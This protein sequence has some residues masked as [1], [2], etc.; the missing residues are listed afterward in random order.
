VSNLIGVRG[1]TEIYDLTVTD[2]VGSPIDLTGGIL[3]FTVKVGHSDPDILAVINKTTVSGAGIDLAVQSGNTL[4]MAY[5]TLEPAD[6][7]LMLAPFDYHYD[8]Q[9]S[10]PAGI[11]TTVEDG[12][13]SLQAD[14]TFAS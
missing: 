11:V 14:V 6:T 10:T 13:F 3:Q 1:D 4:G 5:I 7:E 12:V 8:V 9:W 2:S